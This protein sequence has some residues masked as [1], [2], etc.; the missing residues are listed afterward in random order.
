MAVNSNIAEIRFTQYNRSLYGRLSGVSET[1]VAILLPAPITETRLLVAGTLASVVSE[2][3]T[4]MYVANTQV[5]KGTAQEILFRIVPPVRKLLRRTHERYPCN[6][7]ISYRSVEEGGC[8]GSWQVA[9]AL[10]ISLGGMRVLFEPGAHV[11]PGIEVMFVLPSV[12]IERSGARRGEEGG[13]ALSAMDDKPLRATG[14]VK[15]AGRN[16]EGYAMIGVS[17]HS[18]TPHDK[19]RLTRKITELP[20]E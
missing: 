9:Q 16:R 8:V 20:S 19:L 10:D 2:T 3:D 12:A 18:M 15:H 14:R 4:H 7:T 11:P 5:E 17:F 1:H 13:T 6:M